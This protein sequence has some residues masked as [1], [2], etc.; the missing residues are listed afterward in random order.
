MAVDFK[1]GFDF[2]A[3]NP[4]LHPRS[5]DLQLVGN[6]KQMMIYF[7]DLAQELIDEL[8]RFLKAKFQDTKFIS[9]HLAKQYQ[10]DDNIPLV[11]LLNHCF[12]I[13]FGL[14]Q[15][16]ENKYQKALNAYLKSP[17]TDI[18]KKMKD[19]VCL[20]IFIFHKLAESKQ[21]KHIITAKAEKINPSY[22]YDPQVTA[23][24][25]NEIQSR[26]NDLT[27]GLDI[28]RFTIA[29][30]TKEQ[31]VFAGLIS[32]TKGFHS[33]TEKKLNTKTTLTA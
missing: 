32:R 4:P 28:A 6:T 22:P 25:K 3:A 21:I 23:L 12:P 2:V 26:C 11:K 1:H 7:D 13:L 27:R 14:Q 33:F 9:C 19:K 20:L 29:T 30:N 18:E 31:N 5:K 15:R 10:F 16:S 8:T 24:V 17:M